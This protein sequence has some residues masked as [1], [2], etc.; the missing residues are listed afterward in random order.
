MY[1]CGGGKLFWGLAEACE[2]SCAL[3][4]NFLTNCL[5]LELKSLAI[6]KAANDREQVATCGFHWART[7]GSGA[8]SRSIRRAPEIRSWR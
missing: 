5:N 7:S 1:R 6:L 3:R 2:L 8:T 4:S